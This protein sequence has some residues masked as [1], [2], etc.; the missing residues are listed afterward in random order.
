MYGEVVRPPEHMT[1]PPP[2]GQRGCATRPRRHEG[3]LQLCPTGA[4]LRDY[5]TGQGV[6]QD[7]YEVCQSSWPG[8]YSSQGSLPSFMHTHV[9]WIE[10]LE[11]V[12]IFQLL[13]L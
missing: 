4:S 10:S 1:A 13:K 3:L 12:G 7:C 2:S 9:T 6:I 11:G 8:L 5:G